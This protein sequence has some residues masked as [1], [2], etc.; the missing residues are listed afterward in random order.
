MPLVQNPS[1]GGSQVATLSTTTVLNSAQ[2]LAC[3]T[4]PVNLIPAPG[5]GKIIVVFGAMMVYSFGAHAYVTSGADE[6]DLFFNN[7][8]QDEVTQ[9]FM[10]LL[11]GP[12]SRYLYLGGNAG[13]PGLPADDVNTAVAVGNFATGFAF[14]PIVTATLGAGGLGYAANDTGTITNG[15]NDATYKVLTVGAGGAVLTFQITGAGTACTVANGN[16]TVDGGAQPGVGVGFTV[17][18]TAVQTGDGTLKV[19]TY[20]QIIPVP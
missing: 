6:L 14:G 15:A 9:P 10:S 20:Y 8:Q 7:P 4:V 2:I 5:A 18:I 17:N 3:N 19:V 12:N 11:T 1:L 16:A 13:G